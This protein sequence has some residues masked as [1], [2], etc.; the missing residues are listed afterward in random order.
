MSPGT[1]F[2][3]NFTIGDDGVAGGCKN[4]PAMED[5]NSET[6]DN[7]NQAKNGKPP[8]N[9]SVM[10]NCVSAAR[11]A[12]MAEMVSNGSGFVVWYSV[13]QFNWHCI[14]KFKKAISLIVL[15]PRKGCFVDYFDQGIIAFRNVIFA[16]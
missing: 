5:E 8:R 2:L 14:H 7:S 15:V 1:D 9:L 4:V 3:T 16:D 13:K 12:A 10:R 6:V 11:L